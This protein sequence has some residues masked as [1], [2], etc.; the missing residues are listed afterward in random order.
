MHIEIYEQPSLCSGCE[1]TY[2]QQYLSACHWFVPLYATPV[3]PG[4]R[5]A[6][7][8]WMRSWGLFKRVLWS[9]HNKWLTNLVRN[10]SLVVLSS[11]ACGAHARTMEVAVPCLYFCWE[12]WSS[13]FLTYINV[14]F[15]FVL[16]NTHM[17][18][19]FTLR[20]SVFFSVFYTNSMWIP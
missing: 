5:N 13:P 11:A 14:I 15:F 16:I 1:V 17:V 9:V 8:V 18:Y 10:T 20:R 19:R 6:M 3:T 7:C 2:V 12:H 4:C